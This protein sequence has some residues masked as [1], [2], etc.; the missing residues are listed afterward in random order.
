[1]KERAQDQTERLQ[2]AQSHQ[3]QR[4]VVGNFGVKAK[5]DGTEE[6]IH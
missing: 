5:E 4:E 2:P 6:W 1:V 3:L